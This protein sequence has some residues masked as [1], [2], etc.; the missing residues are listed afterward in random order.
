MMYS[1][2]PSEMCIVVIASWIVRTSSA[3]RLMQETYRW[4]RMAFVVT[5][6]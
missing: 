2:T 1:V 3:W 4:L 5:F 6:V